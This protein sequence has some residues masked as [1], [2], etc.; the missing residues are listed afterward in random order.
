MTKPTM[1]NVRVPEELRRKVK[2]HCVDND[3]SIQDF[4]IDAVG[5]TMMCPEGREVCVHRAKC[6][7][8]ELQIAGDYIKIKE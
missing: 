6:P 3:M 2:R 4:I 5:S 7:F 1:L 8:Y